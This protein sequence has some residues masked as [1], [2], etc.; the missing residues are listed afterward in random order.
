MKRC[1]SCIAV[2]LAVLFATPLYADCTALLKKG[3]TLY[4]PAYSHVFIGDRGC[5]FN[6]TVTLALGR[7]SA[8]EPA[9]AQDA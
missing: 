5:S 7:K 9:F 6:L 2:I 1:L 8:L 3:Q 4:V